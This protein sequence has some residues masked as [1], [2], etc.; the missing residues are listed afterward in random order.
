M[1]DLNPVILGI[2]LLFLGSGFVLLTLIFLRAIPRLQP[3][4]QPHQ[5]AP[6]PVQLPKHSEAVLLVQPGGRVAYI[7]QEARELFNLWEEEPNLERLAR[8]AHP[9]EAFLN[10]CASESQARLSLNGHFVDATSYFAPYGSDSAMLVSMHRPVWVVD[11]QSAE[12]DIQQAKSASQIFNLLTELSQAITANL[13]LEATLQAILVG[14]ENLILFDFSE[15]TLWNTDRQEFTAYRLAGISDIDRHL[16]KSIDRDPYANACSK[17]LISEHNLLHISD[18][19]T[20]K[21]VRLPAGQPKPVYHSYLGVPMLLVGDLIGTIELAT[22]AENSFSQNDLELL[23]MISRQAAVGVHNSLLYEAEQQRAREMSGLASLAQ[24]VSS[25][26]D[27]HDL[28]ARLIE[29][30]ALL[31][32]VEILGFLIYDENQHRLEARQPF[33]GLPV[34]IANWYQAVIQPGS[35]AEEICQSNRQIVATEAPNDPQLEALSL[36]DLAQIASIRHTV[37][38]P[39]TTGGR[40]MGYLQVANK[41]SGAPFTQDDLRLLAIIAGQVAPIIENAALVQESRRRA[42][43]AETLRRIA[44]LTGSNATLDEILKYSLLDLARL[45]QADIAAIYLLDENRGE[46]RIHR[47]STFGISPEDTTPLSRISI[48]D[49]QF[50]LSVTGSKRQFVS[51]NVV[52]SKILPLYRP[53]VESLRLL[54]IIDVPLIVRERCIGE[55][56]L[57]SLRQDFFSRGDVLS[58]STSASQIAAAIEQSA[59]SSQTDQSLRQR[60]DQMTAL[61]R[62]SREINT[63]LDLEH[64]LQRV[65]DEVLLTTH[66]DCGTILLFELNETGSQTHKIS[67]FL[68]D[69]PKED[70]YPLEKIVLEEAESLIIKDFDAI[71]ERQSLVGLPDELLLPAHPEIRSA[72]IVPIAYQGQIAGLIHLHSKK[73]NSFDNAAREIS[74]ALAIQAA[75]ALGNAQRYQEQ[76]RHSELLNRRVETLSRLFEISQVLQTEQS[77]EEALESIAYAIQSATPFEIVLISIY[78]PQSG[79]LQRLT[80]AGIPLSTLD[81]L[82]SH[83]QPWSA[84]KTVLKPD[85]CIG[86]TYFIPFEQMPVVPEDIHTVTLLPLSPSPVTQ[87]H[88]H[89]DDMLVMPLLDAEN[90]PLGLISVD[91]P[92]DKMR[93]DKPTIE[94]LE[95]F[96][97]QAAIAIESHRKLGALKTKVAQI[98]DE[99]KQSQAAVQEAQNHLPALLHKEQEQTLTIRQ[100]TQQA[101]RIHAGLEI[102]EIVNRQ[103]NFENLLEILGQEF[104]TRLGFDIVMIAEAKSAKARVS[105]IVKISSQNPVDVRLLHSQGELPE[106]INPETLLGQRNPLRYSLHNGDTLLVSSLEDHPEWQNT[107][108]LHALNAEAFICLPVLT[109][110]Q[111]NLA[112]L[113]ISH[114]TLA[115]FINEDEHLYTLLSRQVAYAIHNLQLIEQ[116]RHRLREVNLLL[117]FSRQL[118]SLDPTSILHTLVDSA[119]H[120]VQSADAGLVALWDSIQSRLVPQAASGYA[121]N[122]RI[123]DIALQSGEAL[124]GKVFEQNQALRLD[125]VDFARDYN[126]STDNLLTYHDATAGRSPVS[127]LVI[128]IT[129]TTQSTALGVVLLDNFKTIGAFT[130]EDQALISSLAQQTA[131]TLENAHLY[132]ASEQRAGQLEALTSVAATITSSLQP[133]ELIATLLEQLRS[134]LPYDTGILWLGQEDTSG[135]LKKLVVQAALGFA[136]AEQRVGLS[137]AVEDSQLLHEMIVTGKAISV[138]DV[139]DDLRFPSL[140]EY[141]RRSWLG[142]PLIASGKVIGVIALEKE[143]ANFYS[144]DHVQAATTFAGQAAVGLQNASLYQESVR[145]M[146]ELDQST[147]VLE[148]LNRLSVKLSSSLDITQILEF[149]LDEL[150]NTI[151]CTSISAILLN[152]KGKAEVV[153][154]YPAQFSIGPERLPDSPL[155]D[156]LQQTLG[157]FTTEDITQE[158]ELAP[159][160]DFLQR[161]RTRALLALPLATGSSLHGLL[162]AHS[163]DEHRFDPDK[164]ELARTISNQVAIAIQNA[165]L[166]AETRSLTQ[167]LE[168]RVEKRTAELARE[169]QRTETL[170]RVITELSSSLDLD[171]VLNRTLRVLSD[172]IDAEQITI[173]IARPGEEQLYRLAS[174]GYT[175]PVAINGN[176]SK[177]SVDQGLAG[178]IIRERKPA[179]IDDLEKDPRWLEPGETHDRRHRSAIA[180]PLMIGAEALGCLLLYHTELAHFSEDQMELVQGVGNQVAIAVNNAELYRLIRDQAED[181]G[182][183]LRRQQIE[184]SRSKAILEAVADGVLVTDATQSITLFNASAETILGLD[185]SQVLGKSLEYFTGLFGK[186]AQKWRETIHT[187]SQDPNA[188]QLGDTFAEQI[189]L[190]NGH[191]VAVRLAPVSLRKDFLGTV[192]IFQDITHQVEV[193]QL[194]SEFVATVSHELRTPMTSIKGYVEILLMGAAGSL[195][196]QQNHFLEIVKTN[197]E[198]LEVLVNDLLDISRIEAGRVTLSLQPLDLE[199][200]ANEAIEDL[201]HRSQKEN[202]PIRIEKQIPAN[203]PRITGDLDRVRQI[204]DNLLDNAYHYNDPDGKITLRMQHKDNEVQVDI[205]DSGLGIPVEEQ[206]LVFQRFYRGV[207]PLEMGV[208]GTGLG[209]S[210]VQNLIQ[211][212]GGRI[213]LESNGI[214]GEGSTFSFTL[215]VYTAIDDNGNHPQE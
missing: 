7:N 206:S 144:P 69:V 183:M 115:P 161:H 128:P 157:I 166:F 20:F 102:A 81:E 12:G 88:W 64:V 177:L 61:T 106:N 103:D 195:G 37:L 46:L 8:R 70:L 40:T 80:G 176:P 207:R 99:L 142:V 204:L 4:T 194:K 164:V 159:L 98:E 27:P 122:Q 87:A 129:G 65:F 168:R 29:S 31:I 17:Y 18:T 41:P 45:L 71:K 158:A 28:F 34:D 24:A 60:V 192:S 180:V 181:L 107:P 162:L 193:D 95:I 44:S 154:E 202:R 10:L 167:D 134:I 86:R 141:E 190:E 108:L 22:F 182:S 78:E 153:A 105:E 93:P 30:L 2:T 1:A 9:S 149:A 75:I 112:L 58:V 33:K 165:G 55:I 109:E 14:I 38:T 47:E 42:Q 136:D 113:G 35:P 210:I 119:I 16:S 21:G 57:G 96:G 146:M 48:D 135:Q 120:V 56:I 100:M 92:R 97:S 25:L 39:L 187:W 3:L 212:H 175:N 132:Q 90:Q 186:A 116:T 184:T 52:E 83:P 205:Q 140:M 5:K 79:N 43:R 201:I 145:R 84:A 163:D 214:K 114:T 133:D 111:P 179:L 199:E 121:D 203:T 131:L 124:L 139:Q 74:E 148:M 213:W 49:P 54:S 215:P 94:T 178:W 67:L 156:R 68:G 36:H 63:T 150:F 91:A 188:Y 200:V 208:S 117:E 32:D 160:N 189:T 101:E 143:Q 127:S 173:L 73:P 118:G 191:V 59:L 76:V 147:Q 6:I 104:V 170:L 185:R 123:L 89:P 26:S 72:L 126:F 19:H 66:A 197:T 198:R 62:V 130:A 125:D 211:M 23:K 53:L 196:E 51:G 77:L 169:H 151:Q 174:V 209:L 110:Q 15:I 137:V 155:F 172:M 138:P 171:Q 11:S 13:D 82:L 152:A 50:P 85:F